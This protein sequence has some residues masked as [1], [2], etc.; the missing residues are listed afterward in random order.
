MKKTVCLL[1]GVL[2]VAGMLFGCSRKDGT[3]PQ[4]DVRE[5]NTGEAAGAYKIGLV[6]C[7]SYAPLDTMRESFM[8]RLDEDRKSVV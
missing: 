2:L 8:S 5:S 1:L 7:G 6:Q 4:E 3:G